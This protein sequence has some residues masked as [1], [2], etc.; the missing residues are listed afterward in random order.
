M[1]ATVTAVHVVA[2]IAIAIFLNWI[3]L[4]QIDRTNALRF[5]LTASGLYSLSDQ[6][7]RILKN[8]DEPVQMTALFGTGMSEQ[9]AARL[10]RIE[11][12]LDE[13]VQRSGGQL[14]LNA[15]DPAK[16]LDKYEEFAQQVKQRHADQIQ[17]TESALKLARDEMEKTKA[18]CNELERQIK[19]QLPRFATAPPRITGFMEQ[20]AAYLAA[21]PTNLQFDAREQQIKR[22]LQMP[23]PDYAGLRALAAGPFGQ[24]RDDLLSPAAK[25]LKDDA[26]APQTPAALKDVLLNLRD[27]FRKRS[28]AIDKLIE[29]F[30]A[31]QRTD[32]DQAHERIMG[33]NVVVL[34]SA[35]RLSVLPVTDLYMA[36]RSNMENAEPQYVGEEKITGAL[37]ALTMTRRPMVLFVNP[38]PRPAIGPGGDYSHVADILENMNLD[39]REWSPGG[40]QSQ[41]GPLPPQPRPE[42]EPGQK[43][44]M[45][46][47]PALTI[48]GR[49]P[50]NPNEP[51]VVEVVQKHLDE[52]GSAMLILGPSDMMRIGQPDARAKLLEPFGITAR[53]E[54]IVMEPVAVGDRTQASPYLQLSRWP[55][56]HP[57]SAAIGGLPGL[58]IEAVAMEK[59]DSAP[60][61]VTLTPLAVT[62]PDHWLETDL[63]SRDPMEQDADEKTG[64]FTLVMAA[65]RGDQRVVAIGNK[66]F[67]H[68]QVTQFATLTAQGGALQFVQFPA[69][70]EMFANSAYWLSGLDELIATSARSQD[71]R[72]YEQIDAS[73]EIAVN[74]VVLAGLPAA[75]M[76]AGI[77]VWFVRRK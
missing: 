48:P 22:G 21:V 77:L 20:L 70:A 31:L 15:F 35:R 53:T 56:D 72:R 24:L 52:G 44:V 26:D 14:E 37:L 50:F 57:I 3:M 8:L 1:F 39:V 66:I 36:P 54:A 42:P 19:R 73:G 67:A 33:E 49:M 29:T 12:M 32:Y 51:R 69:N 58:M 25:R 16:Q 2:V 43:V 5:D 74:V 7:Q 61:D 23:L 59:S 10:T 4:N 40:R 68:N 71:V 55:E 41:F 60:S 30:D 47:L 6:T 38:G 62:P 34:M 27:A 63:D 11:D 64:P 13:Y 75:C 76:L 18:F 45:I 17:P 46:G 9:A 28:E 65:E